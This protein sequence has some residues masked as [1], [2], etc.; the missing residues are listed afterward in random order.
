MKAIVVIVLLLCMMASAAMAGACGRGTMADYTAPG[1]S[2]TIG[3][4][5]FS[6]FS[7]IDVAIG[8]TVSIPASAVVVVPRSLG[9]EVGFLFVAPWHVG[10]GISLFSQIGYTVTAGVG[11]LV[12]A[13]L[14]LAG[15]G[16]IHDGIASIAETL[17]GAGGSI[18]LSVATSAGGTSLTQ[19][20]TFAGV[21][22]LTVLTDVAV[23]G[24]TSG[25][26][27]ASAV[28]NLFSL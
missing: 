6:S 19:S 21:S 8:T 25:V 27:L 15:C 10:P 28:I 18:N 26:A 11:H 4:L 20:A 12:D 16:F 9:G 1:F 2:C 7:Y 3:S 22:S 24:N 17:S 5:T 14:Q 23:N 13:V